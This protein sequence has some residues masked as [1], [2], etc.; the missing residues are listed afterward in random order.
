M[1][2]KDS[3]TDKMSESVKKIFT[4]AD[5][6][7]RNQK[8]VVSPPLPPPL[9][10]SKSLDY[11]KNYLKNFFINVSSTDNKYKTKLCYNNTT[12][13]DV[14]CQFMY[15]NELRTMIGFSLEISCTIKLLNI[16]YKIITLNY[17][18]KEDYSDESIDDKFLE[19]VGSL[20]VIEDSY[21]YIYIETV[22]KKHEIMIPFINLE[23][24]IDSLKEKS[25][26]NTV[27]ISI[28]KRTRNIIYKLTE[29][30]MVKLYDYNRIVSGTNNKRN[31]DGSF[32]FHQSEVLNWR[33]FICNERYGCKDLITSS[34]SR[35]KKCC[36]KIHSIAEIQY[37]LIHYAN[38]IE[39]I[40]KNSFGNTFL[41]NYHSYKNE[42]GE[43]YFYS[44]HKT[45][46]YFGNQ[47]Y[48]I[49]ICYSPV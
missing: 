18:I 29:N 48:N 8:M 47:G 20:Y 26:M 46:Q 42:D 13:N 35:G 28:N 36:H 14:D 3:E 22:E 7:K 43:N 24:Y 44:D 4:C 31:S 10:K 40:N 9:P 25:K 17:D 45:E 37:A 49:P 2:D 21:H 11:K 32:M 30:L 27:T 19:L 34:M 23:N 16:L 1:D 15:V 6:L 38:T 12:T 5:I 39:K 41:N 33:Y